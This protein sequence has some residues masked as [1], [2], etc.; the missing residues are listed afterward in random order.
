M[1][2]ALLD[3]HVPGWEALSPMAFRWALGQVDASI[4]PVL[5]T[6]RDTVEPLPAAPAPTT[7]RKRAT[8]GKGR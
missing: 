6:A 7:P 4:R 3:Q 5:R 8:P 1:S 2:R